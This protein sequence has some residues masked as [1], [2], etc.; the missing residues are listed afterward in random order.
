M[1]LFEAVVAAMVAKSI[2]IR[3]ANHIPAAKEALAKEWNKLWDMRCWEVEPVCEYDEVRNKASK[4]NETV[5]FGR[6]FP[7]VVERIRAT[8]RSAQV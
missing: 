8:A 5:H 4:A 3:E 6:G 7:I 2:P 1:D